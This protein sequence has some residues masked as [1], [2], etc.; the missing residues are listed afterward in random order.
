[1]T[2]SGKVTPSSALWRDYRYTMG[3]LKIRAKTINMGTVT[4]PMHRRVERIACA[5]AGN[6]P[7]KVSAV[8]GFLPEFLKLRTEPEVLEPGQEGL[9][10][11]ELD[12]RKLSGQKG[13]KSFS[14]LLEGVS[15]RPSDRTIKINM[16]IK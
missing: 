2:I 4:A 3:H 1:M 7:L 11:V 8:K 5:N 9:L 13:K 14:V 12:G 10:M 15:G 16:D 6:E